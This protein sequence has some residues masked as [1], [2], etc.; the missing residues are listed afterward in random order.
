MNVLRRVS[1]LIVLL[2]L[3][4]GAAALAAEETVAFNVET[5]K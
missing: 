3:V 1:A 4:A 2:A 5:K